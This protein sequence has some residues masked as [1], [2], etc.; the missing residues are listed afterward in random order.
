MR[1]S[2]PSSVLLDARPPTPGSHTPIYASALLSLHL[3]HL[4]VVT[5]YLLIVNKQA[6]KCIEDYIQLSQKRKL[7]SSFE[8]LGPPVLRADQM[9]L[10][11]L[12]EKDD[13]RTST[14]HTLLLPDNSSC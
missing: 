12:A 7:D 9:I 5:Y 13:V 8:F 3:L 11:I 10:S 2:K 14:A 4:V 1:N 6:Y